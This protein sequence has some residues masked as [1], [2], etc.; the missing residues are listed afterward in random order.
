MFEGGFAKYNQ[1]ISVQ[2]DVPKLSKRFSIQHET[3]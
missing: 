2:Y 1:N 3:S